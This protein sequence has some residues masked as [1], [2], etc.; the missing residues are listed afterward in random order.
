MNYAAHYERLIERA[1]NRVLEGYRER[2]HILP[3]CMGG[4]NAPDNLVDLTA[5]MGQ[6]KGKE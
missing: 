2:H 3:R 6:R 5:Y 1:K 4:T